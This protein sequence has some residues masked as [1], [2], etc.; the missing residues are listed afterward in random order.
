MPVTATSTAPSTTEPIASAT[1]TSSSVL[2]LRAGARRGA[3][4][5]GSCGSRHSRTRSGMHCGIGVAAP[6]AAGQPVASDAV[7]VAVSSES[8]SRHSSQ[9][10]SAPGIGRILRDQQAAVGQAEPRGIAEFGE[11]ERRHLDAV[12][13]LG[14][15][16]RG[17]DRRD[18]G[19]VGLRI[20]VACRRA[21]A[22]A[23]MRSASSEPAGSRHRGTATSCRTSA[24]PNAARP[25]TA[26][27]SKAPPPR[28]SP[29]SGW[30]RAA[31]PRERCAVRRQCRPARRVQHGRVTPVTPTQ[32]RRRQRRV[33]SGAGRGAADG[34]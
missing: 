2:P 22:L 16:V 5:Q 28:P 21:P 29:R 8:G 30:R 9:M 6:T 13:D 34:R 17:R 12:A 1:R 15:A 10:V 27:R 23:R 24:R 20:D 33:G 19:L 7:A 31:S 32:M 4:A 25:S 18:A 11:V 14:R 26:C 3:D